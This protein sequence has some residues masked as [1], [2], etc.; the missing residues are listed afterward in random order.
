MD[1]RLCLI[2]ERGCEILRGLVEGGIGD[3]TLH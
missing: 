1:R 2:S 3:V